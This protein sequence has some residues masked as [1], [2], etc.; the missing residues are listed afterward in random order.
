MAARLNIRTE[1]SMMILSCLVIL[2]PRFAL[3]EQV[4]HLA[5]GLDVRVVSAEEIAAQPQL[6]GIPLAPAD[7]KYYPFDEAQV[8]QALET[9]TGFQ[10][11]LDVDVFI[12]PT[13]PSQVASSYA[14]GQVIYL[15]P[16][17]GKV[18]PSTVA[19]I[20]THEMGHVLTAA[21]LDGDAARWDAYMEL[22]GL[23]SV[24]NGPSAA[25][26]DRAREILAEDF[27]FLFGGNLAT[28]SG[29]IENHELATPDRVFGLEEMLV[30]FVAGR[31]LVAAPVTASAYPNPCNPRTT[32]ALTLADSAGFDAGRASLRVFDIRGA[33]VKTIHGARRV[34][35]QLQIDWNGDD[36]SGSAVASGRYLYVIKAGEVQ[37]SGSVTLVR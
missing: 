12:L 3:A 35:E 15:A 21:F 37:A 20:T 9:M 36:N 7:R 4:Y 18:D 2:A 23:D 31:A 13:P 6:A 33:L 25:H 22:R 30:D 29:S 5:N 16:G 26:A 11:D 1:I 27:R 24:A 14:R 17:F 10:T 32:V 8:V 19:Y 34:G 28:A